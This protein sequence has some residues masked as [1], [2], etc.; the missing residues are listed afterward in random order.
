MPLA[1][2]PM[3]SVAKIISINAEEKTRHHLENLGLV[4][5]AS[6]TTLA[7]ERGDVILR[8]KDGRVAL[9]RGLAMRINVVCA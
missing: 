4:V 9:N 2:A 1:M 3:G 6:L 8:V 7:S 5:G